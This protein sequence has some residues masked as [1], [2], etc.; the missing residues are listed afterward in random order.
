MSQ[1]H[2]LGGSSKERF[3]YYEEDHDNLR[4]K[5]D[6]LENHGFLAAVTPGNSRSTE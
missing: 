6:V 4:G 5:I 2:I 1:W 3:V